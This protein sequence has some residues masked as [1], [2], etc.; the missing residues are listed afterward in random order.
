M[1]KT[2]RRAES[3][4]SSL[5]FCRGTCSQKEESWFID[6]DTLRPIK[7]QLV[8][9]RHMFT[10]IKC[11]QIW[12]VRKCKMFINEKCCG[13]R[14]FAHSGQ[15]KKRCGCKNENCL[16][17]PQKDAIWVHRKCIFVEKLIV[18]YFKCTKMVIFILKSSESTFWWEEI[19]QW[20]IK[21]AMRFWHVLV[22]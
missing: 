9:S 10:N 15:K 21:V 3:S 22:K 14:M 19:I 13:H 17:V 4:G 6:C 18:F 5:L 16:S 12:N 8:N 20:W 1:S 7:L 11:S 2:V